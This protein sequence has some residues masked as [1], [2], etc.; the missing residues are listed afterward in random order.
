[1][2]G[3]SAGSVCGWHG[4]RGPQVREKPAP[5][6]QEST[7]RCLGRPSLF[8]YL[9]L[10]RGE[11]TIDVQALFQGAWSFPPLHLE[12]WVENEG[13]KGRREPWGGFRPQTLPLWECVQAEPAPKQNN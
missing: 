11:G 5:S 1:M 9:Y 8:L 3:G 7:E 10:Q 6:S 13:E 2:E 4:A 12:M